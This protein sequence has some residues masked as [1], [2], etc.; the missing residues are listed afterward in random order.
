MIKSIGKIGLRN[1]EAHKTLKWIYNDYGI[2]RC[3]LGKLLKNDECTPN[4]FLGFAHKEKRIFY[5]VKDNIPLLA[6]FKHTVLACQ[7]CHEII[8]T[9]KK[10]T[11]EV[12][13]KLRPN[14][15]INKELTY[16]NED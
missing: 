16:V 5:R 14:K 2:S 9:D 11:S 15:C 7:S 8:E 1:I 3:E 12:F 6:S 10:K 13:A 4:N